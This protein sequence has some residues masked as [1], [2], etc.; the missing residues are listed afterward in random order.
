MGPRTD[1]EALCHEAMRDRRRGKRVPL[2][3]AIE[4]SGL[5]RAGRLF[6]EHTTTTNI[7]EDGCCFQIKNSLER[8]DVVAIKLLRCQPEKPLANRSLLFQIAW[9]ARERDGWFAGAVKLQPETIWP[10]TFP[11]KGKLRPSV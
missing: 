10:A 7:S 4:V 11:P 1:W 6:T 5:D 2:T 9:T 8:G 3:Y